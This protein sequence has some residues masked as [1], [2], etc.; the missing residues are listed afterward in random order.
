MHEVQ[1]FKA[2]W[3]PNQQMT[4]D[5]G[6]VMYKGKYCPIRQYMPNKP[7]RF[8]IKVWAA[9]DA[10]S[11]YVW[12]FQIYCG[13]EGNPHDENADSSG[14]DEE[15]F[16]VDDLPVSSGKGEG[17]QGR[18]VVKHL[19]KDLGGRGHIVTTNTF[20]TSVPLFLDLLEQGIMATG[21]LKSNR[22]YVPKALFAKEITKK[23]HYG[24]IDYCMHEEGQICCAVWK[25]KN[26]VILLS[27]HA[28]PVSPPGPRQFVYRRIAKKKKKVNTGPMHLQYTKNMRGV[29]TADQLRG[30]YSCLTRSHK[31]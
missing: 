5:E 17:L 28:E 8:G 7:V 13:K 15:D 21:T 24:W 3:A 19:L 27:T 30:V 23:Q 4:V 18:H 25:D 26:A 12:N 22:K 31:W 14:S 20:F 11:K 6:M 9:A 16:I 1:A 10:L 29:D 2:M